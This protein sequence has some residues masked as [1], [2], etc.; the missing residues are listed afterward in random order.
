MEMIDKLSKKSKDA[1]TGFDEAARDY[2]WQIDQGTGKSVDNSE[3]LY[4]ETH[5]ALIKRVLY[6]EKKIKKLKTK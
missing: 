2:G 4:H 6:L 3:D 5:E 1:I